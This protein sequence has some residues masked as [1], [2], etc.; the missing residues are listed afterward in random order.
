VAAK[1]VPLPY[2]PALEQFVLPNEHDI[3][4]AVKDVLR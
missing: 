2:A 4:A 1:N 3:I